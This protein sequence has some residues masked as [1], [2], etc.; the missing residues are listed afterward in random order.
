[1]R[2]SGVFAVSET[3][4]VVRLVVSSNYFLILP[5]LKIGFFQ[6]QLVFSDTSR[7][8]GQKRREKYV[9]RNIF[10]KVCCLS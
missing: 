9:Y 2:D 8:T 1:V 3:D 5:V 6:S 10:K 7:D 4:E